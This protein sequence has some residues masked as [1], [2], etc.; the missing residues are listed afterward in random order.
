M[1]LFLNGVHA[2]RVALRYSRTPRSAIIFERIKKDQSGYR[3]R[4]FRIMTQESGQTPSEVINLPLEMSRTS[5][6]TKSN[7]MCLGSE[8][9]KNHGPEL[10]A[11]PVCGRLPGLAASFPR[12]CPV[13]LSLMPFTT[14]ICG[15]KT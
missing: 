5:T 13:L 7:I 2:E 15:T 10:C 9:F 12:Q 8:M 1:R 4:S 6:K 14:Q 11:W 3:R